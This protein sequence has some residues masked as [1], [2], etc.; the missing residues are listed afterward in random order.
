MSPVGDQPEKWQEGRETPSKNCTRLSFLQ[1]FPVL[2]GHRRLP[3][4]LWVSDKNVLKS[5]NGSALNSFLIFDFF[6]AIIL[7]QNEEVS[8]VRVQ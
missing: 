5:F 6:R 7:E 1:K 3:Q 8:Q 4:L 2:K